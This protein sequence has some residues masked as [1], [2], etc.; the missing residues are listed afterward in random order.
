MA[1]PAASNQSIHRENLSNTDWSKVHLAD[2]Q[3]AYKNGD[4]SPQDLLAL[5]EKHPDIKN[6]TLFPQGLG[7]DTRQRVAE[8]TRRL[9]EGKARELEGVFIAIKIY[10][11]TRKAPCKWEARLRFS[12]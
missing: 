12:R 11:L 3:T 2:V 1:L 10:F 7:A 6:P 5:L 8:S 9:R 4:L